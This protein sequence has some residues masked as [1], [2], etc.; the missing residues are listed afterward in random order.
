MGGR[1]GEESSADGRAD[2][3]SLDL[4]NCALYITRQERR[5]GT[6]WGQA[7]PCGNAVGGSRR[8]LCGGNRGTMLGMQE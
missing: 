7:I 4:G 3:T 1:E 6:R 5:R 2:E 8:R